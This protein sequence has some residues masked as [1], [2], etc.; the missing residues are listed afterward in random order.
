MWP[1][2]SYAGPST[3]YEI[4]CENNTRVSGT[5]DGVALGGSR[6]AMSLNLPT[7]AF[8]TWDARR[9][10]VDDTVDVNDNMRWMGLRVMWYDGSQGRSD[11]DA[12]NDP[13]PN[14]TSTTSPNAQS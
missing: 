4:D 5:H 10:A 8:I 13:T 3:H 7:N 14:L 11:N 2:L 12:A 6:L 9:T 1:V